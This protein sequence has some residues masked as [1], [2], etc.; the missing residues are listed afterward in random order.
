MPLKSRSRDQA[1]RI[2]LNEKIDSRGS[3]DASYLDSAKITAIRV[4]TSTQRECICIWS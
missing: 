1:A 4:D 3:R 2:G